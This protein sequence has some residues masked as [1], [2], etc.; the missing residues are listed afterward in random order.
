MDWPTWVSTVTSTQLSQILS[1]PITC[2]VLSLTM[3]IAIFT[4][5]SSITTITSTALFLY[6]LSTVVMEMRTAEAFVTVM[7]PHR[8]VVIQRS[9]SFTTTTTTTAS[10]TTLSMA[11][12]PLPMDRMGET[13]RMLLERRRIQDL[14]LVQ[15]L[16]KTVKMDGLDGLRA[17]VWTIYGI[18]NVVFPIMATVMMAGMCLNLVGYGYY[19]DHDSHKMI[20]DTL[21]HIRQEYTYQQELWRIA[22]KAAAGA[23]ATTT[24]GLL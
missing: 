11:D 21:E 23:D 6:Y 17:M 14:G 20:I 16:G 2:I 5:R 3:T 15:E 8:G 18:S 13:E 4:M 19:W 12:E 22:V 10:T 1:S 9:F 7:T 24:Q